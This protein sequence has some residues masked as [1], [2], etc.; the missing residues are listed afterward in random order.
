MAPISAML[1][2]A[3]LSLSFL[4][5]YRLGTVIYAKCSMRKTMHTSGRVGIS[6]AVKNRLLTWRITSQK[7]QQISN[8]K[9]M[10]EMEA[11]LPEVLRLLCTA[12][13]SG[14]SL[15]MA[16]RYAAGNCDEPLR[17]EL[18]QTVWDIEAGQSFDEAIEGLRKRTDSAEFAYL[19]VAMEIQHR[20]GGSL[21]EIL[22]TVA[23]MLKQSAELK[24]ELRTKTAQGRLSS[25]IVA[26]MPFALLAIFSIF[27]PGYLAGFFGS[28]L[29]IFLFAFALLLEAAGVALVFRA[30]KIDFT[31]D[32]EGGA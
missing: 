1:L 32:L 27:S 19:S 30:L 22:T 2:I 7:V 14:S 28:P 10:A 25:R 24:E 3:A 12:L 17:S 31:V 29:G 18:K 26:L 5:A 4:F 21:T 8:H 9:R 16:L 6:E 23:A 15:L 11:E 13:E 20:S